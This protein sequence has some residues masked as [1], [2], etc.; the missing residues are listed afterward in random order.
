MSSQWVTNLKNQTDDIHAKLV[1]ELQ[2]FLNAQHDQANLLRELLQVHEKAVADRVSEIQKNLTREMQAF[3]QRML[4]TQ[5]RNSLAMMQ[6]I[7]AKIE[8]FMSSANEKLQSLSVVAVEAQASPKIETRES[9][10]PADR[11]VDQSKPALHRKK[12]ASAS[13]STY[14]IASH[15]SASSSSL[16]KDAPRACKGRSSKRKRHFNKFDHRYDYVG[17]DFGNWS[18]PYWQPQQVARHDYRKNRFGGVIVCN[19]CGRY[20]H[21]EVNCYDRLALQA[22]LNSREFLPPFYDSSRNFDQFA[23]NCACLTSQFPPQFCS[24]MCFPW[25]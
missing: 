15:G 21:H 7:E 1:N 14:S 12:S 25:R 9:C 10:V 4:Q 2:P 20:N 6:N 17:S 13:S 18:Y 19:F 3:A 5:E 8:S 11:Q 22:Q 16:H 24:R 23:N